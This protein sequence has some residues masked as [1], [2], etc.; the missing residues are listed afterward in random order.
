MTQHKPHLP[1]WRYVE[2]A[3]D[4]CNTYQCLACAKQWTART[5]P[6]Y[7]N[8]REKVDGP[9]EGIDGMECGLG[10]E[11]YTVYFRDLP[12]PQYIA[13][14][15]FCPY[16]GIQWESPIR[17]NVGNERM[18]GP[19][20]LRQEKAIRR[21]RDRAFQSNQHDLRYY[22]PTWWWLIQRRLYYPDRHETRKWEDYFKLDPGKYT[23]LQIR[24][25]LQEE[26]DRSA[27]ADHI[28]IS[29]WQYRAFPIRNKGQHIRENY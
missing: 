4:G 7:F 12:S 15:E 8:L 25:R 23:A 3:D 17:C 13:V 27:N 11:A 9:G 16:C 14:W 29:Q 26:R 21:C 1:Y 10:D 20:R 28:C 6:G 2:Y 22:E 5:E 24:E 18:F 19:R